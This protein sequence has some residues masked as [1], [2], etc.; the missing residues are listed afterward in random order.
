MRERR[1]SSWRIGN[2]N[3]ERLDHCQDFDA[4][5][6]N[7]A[8]SDTVSANLSPH[9]EY[10]ARLA[11]WNITVSEFIDIHATSLV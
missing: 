9:E 6:S 3:N 2:N 7:V 4:Y 11:F 1:S 8:V 10:H 5:V